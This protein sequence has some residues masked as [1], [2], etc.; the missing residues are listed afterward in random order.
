VTTDD[1]LVTFEVLMCDAGEVA[2]VT[3]AVSVA[4]AAAISI[5]TSI[6]S[7]G[8]GVLAIAAG[9]GRSGASSVTTAISIVMGAQ[10]FAASSGLSVNMTESYRDALSATDW[11]FGN[12][13]AVGAEGCPSPA[14]PAPIPPLVASPPATTPTTTLIDTSTTPGTTLVMGLLTGGGS[15]CNTL[16]NLLFAMM[17]CI[18][19]LVALQALVHLLWTYR[20]NR[21]WYR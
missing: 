9:G 10:R 16:N 21:K 15:P 5:G 4:A 19:V 1:D 6:I 3:V 18:L 7:M 12:V 14:A 8:T 20:V 13:D 11:T 17:C 2:S